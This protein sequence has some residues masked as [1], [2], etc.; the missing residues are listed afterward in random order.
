MATGTRSTGK[1]GDQDQPEGPTPSPHHADAQ[2]HDEAN[3]RRQEGDLHRAVAGR[4]PKGLVVDLRCRGQD[5]QQAGHGQQEEP[6][7]QRLCPG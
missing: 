6:K 7:N 4:Q 3:E 2:Q 1:E 5:H